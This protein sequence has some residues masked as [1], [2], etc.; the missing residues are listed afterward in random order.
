MNLH[1]SNVTCQ[2][3][4]IIIIMIIMIII[5]KMCN[6]KWTTITK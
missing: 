2:D 4:I 3:E 1:I 5:M 6:V